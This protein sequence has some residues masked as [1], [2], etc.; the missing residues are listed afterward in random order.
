MEPLLIEQVHLTDEIIDD[1]QGHDLHH[2]QF[3]RTMEAP[4]KKGE[5]L[6]IFSLDVW[7]NYCQ[8]VLITIEQ[9]VP[10]RTY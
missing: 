4:T 2:I 6:D 1:L 8:E 7:C 5:V 10:I 9:H 3:R